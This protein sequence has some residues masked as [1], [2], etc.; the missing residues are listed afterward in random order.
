MRISGKTFLASAALCAAAFQAAAAPPARID[1]D[2][3]QAPFSA[4][5]KLVL[6]EDESCT[7]QLGPSAHVAT[8]A[9]H[10]FDFII[11]GIDDQASVKNA[12]GSAV[13]VTDIY[14]SEH[15]DPRDTGNKSHFDKAIVVL[16]QAPAPPLSQFR[17]RA[18]D[19]PKP[20]AGNFLPLPVTQAGFPFDRQGV[21]SANMRCTLSE[22]QYHRNGRDFTLKHDCAIAPGDSGSA[23][24][25]VD[26]QDQRA[27]VT[28][29][30]HAVPLTQAFVAAYDK[31]ASQPVAP[32]PAAPGIKVHRVPM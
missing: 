14:I 30:N 8:T 22:P 21:L 11:L 10:C 32:N 31:I 12:D 2:P 19:A 20:G 18:I 1:P 28:S 9:A 24:W 3:D 23:A 17:L 16:E 27:I 25:D 4:I 13:R 6:Q 15:Y 29:L 5:R 26:T 7:L